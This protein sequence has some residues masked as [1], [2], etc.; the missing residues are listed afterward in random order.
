MMNEDFFMPANFAEQI[1]LLKSSNSI[2]EFDLIASSFYI[3]S[4]RWQQAK[5][6][7]LLKT[8]SLNN[9]LYRCKKINK[10]GSI[11]RNLKGNYA[12]QSSAAIIQ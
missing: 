6:F 8:M 7:E 2:D 12:I 4:D 9:I 10:L 3:I 11:L 1:Q 5:F